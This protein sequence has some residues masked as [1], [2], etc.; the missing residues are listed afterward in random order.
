MERSTL[1]DNDSR[2]LAYLRGL[3]I[4]GIVLS[5]LGGWLFPPYTNFILVVVPLF[6]FISGTVSYYSF[7]RS[8]TTSQYL[9]KRLTSLLVPYYLAC[10]LCLFVYMLTHSS[11]PEITLGTLGAWLAIRP[12][13]DLQG[14]PL[15]QVW[16]LNTLAVILIVSP[17]Y[18][19][20]FERKPRLASLLL[21]L[22]VALAAVQLVHD[23]HTLFVI[24]GQNLYKPLVHSF[25]FIAGFIYFSTKH[26]HGKWLLPV[27]TGGSLLIAV[28]L[29]FAFHLRVDYS[30]HTFSPDLYYVAGSAAAIGAFLLCENMLLH[31]CAK[32]RPIAWILDFAYRYTFAIFLLHSFAIWAAERYLGLVSPQGN[33]VLYAVAKFT[34]VVVLTCLLAVPFTRISDWLVAKCRQPLLSA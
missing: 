32:V 8:S 29:V 12:T 5:H 22:P 17:L 33:F 26:L 23:V 20:L 13:R 34:F 14:F 18:Y 15:G 25:F 4:I 30:Y 3:A 10:L 1:A 6:F 9:Q 11:L 21:L 16:F 19:I 28:G 7:L 24:C 2:F 27:T 31:I